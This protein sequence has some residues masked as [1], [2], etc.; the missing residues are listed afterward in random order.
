MAPCSSFWTLEKS[1]NGNTLAMDLPMAVQTTR[2][3]TYSNDMLLCCSDSS[4]FASYTCSKVSGRFRFTLLALLK[5]SPAMKPRKL[6]SPSSW[7]SFAINLRKKSVQYLSRFS[8]DTA[9]LFDGL[10]QSNLWT[11][12]S[13]FSNRYGRIT[14]SSRRASLCLPDLKLYL[15]FYSTLPGVW[16]PLAD[17]N[18]KNR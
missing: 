18:L 6:T 2:M 5:D 11:L 12:S 17:V 8:F 16:I 15:R 13:N 7:T 3:L 4:C 10:P 9:L 1:R 14:S